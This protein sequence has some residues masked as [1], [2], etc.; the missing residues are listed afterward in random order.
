VSTPI[1]ESPTAHDYLVALLTIAVAILVRAVMTPLMGTSFPL[2]TM[3]SAVAFSAWYSGWRPALFTAVGG[4]LAADAA[5][6]P[7]S[8][9]IG[10]RPLVPELFSVGVYLLSCGSIIV[11]GEAMRAAQR[12]LIAGQRAL[13]DAN[14]ALEQKVEAHALLAAI[15]ASTGDSIISTTL[16]GT[17][18]SWNAGAEQLF[19]YTAAEALGRGM[20]MLVPPD[21]MGEEQVILERIQSG[22]RVDHLDTVRV[23]K[24]GALRDVSLTV[25]PL[26]D[27][28]GQVIGTSAVARDI[29]LRKSAE[30]QL[31]RSEEEQRLLVAIHDATRGLHDASEVLRE[32]VTEVGRHFEAAR[33]A[34]GEVDLD[35]GTVLITRGYTRDLPTVAG[36]YPLSVFGEAMV[37]ALQA[38][39][40]VA[41][42]DVRTSP[43]TSTPVA[44]R[45]YDQMQIVSL[46]CVPLMRSQR[47]TAILVMT[48]TRPRAWTPGEA[49]LLAQIAERTLFAVESARAA[50]ALRESRD[51]LA[52]A[53]GAGQMGAWSRDV[54]NNIVWWSPELEAIAGLPPGGFAG[55]EEGFY[56]LVHEEDRAPV[57]QAIELALRSRTDYKVEF[58][59]RHGSGQWRWMEGR[60]RAVY[61][62]DGEPRMLYGLGIDITERRRAV[63]E[64]QD[65]DRRKDE[66]LATLAHELRNPLAPIT[67]G[68][69]ILRVT[70]GRGEAAAQARAVMERQVAQMA[71]LVDDLLDVARISTGKT[72]LRREAMDLADAVRD[73]VDTSGPL[74][75]AGGQTLTVTLP[76]TPMVVSA[77]RTRMAQVFANLLNN[78]A[79]FSAPHQPIAITVEREG[80]E[81]VVRVRDWGVGIHPENLPRIFD[82]FR[83]AGSPGGRS[84]GG[85][86]IGLFLVKR[87]VEMHGGRV[88]AHSGGPGLGSEFVV[89]LPGVQ[90]VAPA[91]PRASNGNAAARVATRRI[92]V[93]DDNV[94]AA[95]LLATMLEIHGHETRLAH[96]GPEA[97]AVAGDYRPDVVV[98]DIGL[99]TIDGHETAKWI[100]QQPWGRDILLVAVTGWGHPEERRRSKEAGFD[101]HLVKPADP[102]M[103]ADLIAAPQAAQVR[104][105]S[106][107]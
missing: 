96:D 5:F 11:L 29:T 12:R 64:L 59:Y 40:P 103:L 22:G 67:S 77:D 9:M 82:M 45:T 20:S 84:K 68:L 75:T 105:S 6:I 88:E 91:L 27:R 72:E 69:H 13:S 90:G 80:D 92:L 46:V 100:R 10:G 21:R 41:I 28:H 38:G 52:L 55:S 60:G 16:G 62:P 99:P 106:D 102:M 37:A 34:Y 57:A 79:K 33:C 30:R 51:V 61:A 23:T 58:R 87:M 47:L 104:P 97:M 15:V 43:L 93:V 35:S 54:V 56:A 65:A 94:D 24:N 26:H 95:S 39:R 42:E 85:L 81:A 101:H 83:Q 36:R 73:A 66:F 98:L 17:I 86:G 14:R 32:A 7:G 1:R 70:D 53:M 18:T 63:E 76:S 107:E 49:D 44:A 31:L 2:A 50:A 19:G 78:S 71:R 3:F 4:F 89:R 25:S 8:G 48:D 74:V